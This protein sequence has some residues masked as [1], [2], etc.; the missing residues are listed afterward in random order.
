VGLAD[1]VVSPYI[2]E[3]LLLLIAVVLAIACL[4]AAFLLIRHAPAVS[5]GLVGA[6]IV[7]SSCSSFPLLMGLVASPRT[8]ASGRA[9]ACGSGELSA[10][11][12]RAGGRR[13][14][15]FGMC[16]WRAWSSP[17]FGAALL[18]LAIQ[19][20]CP[21]YVMRGS[22]Y[23]FYEVD[24]LGAWASYVTFLF[25]VDVLVVVALLLISGKQARRDEVIRLG[26]DEWSR[27]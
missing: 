1:R 18:V 11:S 4:V 3:G 15:R 9:S 20:A 5:M 17:P 23:C 13:R 12:P 2:H 16:P 8:S 27:V 21:L 7:G 14:R 22:G 24:V 26:D 19:Q 10:S 25:I 6:V